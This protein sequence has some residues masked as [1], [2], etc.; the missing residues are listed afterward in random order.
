MKNIIKKLLSSI[1]TRIGLVWWL[2]IFLWIKTLIAYFA[3]FNGL[4]GADFIDSL[5][6]FI[7]P[8][9]FTITVFS[10]SLFIKRT[11]LLYTVLGL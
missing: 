9:G 3:V 2:A 1:N 5:M 10:L 8:L 6:I 11:G 4:G 7:N